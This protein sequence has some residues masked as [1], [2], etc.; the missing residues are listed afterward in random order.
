MGKASLADVIAMTEET[1]LDPLAEW[2]DGYGLY[3]VVVADDSD[4][5]ILRK[6][7]GHDVAPRAVYLIKG[8]IPP[9]DV[10]DE[11]DGIKLMADPEANH[12]RF[13][14]DDAELAV[15]ALEGCLDGGEF[16]KVIL[17]D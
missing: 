7:L 9:E 8:G 16:K 14:V 10:A 6:Y 17:D 15:D 12:S 5:S 2:P 4:P 11:P 1:P 3:E 13:V